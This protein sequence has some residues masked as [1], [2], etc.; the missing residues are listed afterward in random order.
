MNGVD[1]YQG[2]MFQYGRFPA[3]RDIHGPPKGR[4]DRLNFHQRSRLFG[5]YNLLF[6][7]LF[8]CRRCCP[9]CFIDDLGQLSEAR[10][11]RCVCF[12]SSSLYFWRRQV[13][14]SK[15]LPAPRQR[16][17]N[18]DA[19]ALLAVVALDQTTA[20]LAA[21]EHVMPQ[22]N[23]E[24]TPSR[25]V[26]T[27]RSTYAAVSTGSVERPMIFVVM[28]AKRTP[29][30]EDAASPTENRAGPTRRFSIS[31]DASATLTS[32]TWSAGATE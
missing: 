2:H 7:S 29:E 14:R 5:I 15:T 13:W 11:G 28:A 8:A 3:C 19:V 1:A 12:S 22:Q 32:I 24:H 20:V 25:A 18:L 27:V 30:A 23:A 10:Q 26:R 17:V 9:S 31:S 21:R 16:I 4:L 6:F